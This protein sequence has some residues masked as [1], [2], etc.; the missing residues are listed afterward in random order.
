MKVQYGA[1]WSCPEDWQNFDS[2]PALRIE[3]LPL[4][5]RFY[6]KNASRFPPNVEYGDIV[7]GLPVADGSCDF[8]YCSHVLEHLALDEFFTAVRNSFHLLKPGGLWRLVMPDLRH[9]ADKYLENPSAS[10]SI[11]FLKSCSLG[12]PA[13]P[14]GLLN[15]IAVY[16]GSS[17]HRW[18]WDYASVEAALSEAGFVDI[19]RA[20]FGDCEVDEFRSIEQEDR[21]AN[22]LGVQCR[23]P[24]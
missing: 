2:S 15:K 24:I 5:G 16:S 18:L 8:L 23:R 3:K 20:A 10:A 14:K 19:R 21:W 12:F 1:G 4:V 17:I 7:L 22:A 13:R 6:T 11:D 9:E